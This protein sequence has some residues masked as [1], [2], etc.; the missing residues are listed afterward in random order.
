MNYD[1]MTIGPL[2]HTDT[3]NRIEVQNSSLY[4]GWQQRLSINNS[5]RPPCYYE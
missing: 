5:Y 2:G 4:T 1:R 3:Y